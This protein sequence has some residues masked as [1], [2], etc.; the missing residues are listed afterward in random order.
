MGNIESHWLEGKQWREKE[1]AAFTQGPYKRQ[2][3]KNTTFWSSERSYEWFRQGWCQKSSI[4][5]EQPYSIEEAK[6]RC[7][8]GIFN[9]TP[10]ASLSPGADGE[11]IQA[12]KPADPLGTL[13][14]R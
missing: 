1:C 5:L 13:P 12:L 4:E 11:S 3:D 9:P 2:S 7:E 10:A 8:L 6:L 14:W